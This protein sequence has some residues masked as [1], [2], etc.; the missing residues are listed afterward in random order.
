[1]CA[2]RLPGTEERDELIRKLWQ[3]A[4]IVLPTGASGVRF[5]PA[6]TVSPADIDAAVDAVHSALTSVK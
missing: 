3:R 2:F 5:R 4:V 1:M 6:L